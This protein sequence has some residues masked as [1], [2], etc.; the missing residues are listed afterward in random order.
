[1]PPFSL[2]R[3]PPRSPLP[4]SKSEKLPEAKADS[5]TTAATAIADER[6]AEDGG[7]DSGS[8]DRAAKRSRRN[9]T[10]DML[11]DLLNR[12]FRG[13]FSATPQRGKATAPQRQSTVSPS[14]RLLHVPVTVTPAA[15]VVQCSRLYSSLLTCTPLASRSTCALHGEHGLCDRGTSPPQGFGALAPD[16]PASVSGVAAPSGGAR[17]GVRAAMTR[18]TSVVVPPSLSQRASSLHFGIVRSS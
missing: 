18:L 9:S 11:H 2:L 3:R 14:C 4:P 8:A 16:R 13:T 1:M 5:D 10:R 12:S 17:S 6:D 15:A 7:G